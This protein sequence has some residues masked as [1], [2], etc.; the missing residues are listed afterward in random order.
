MVGPKK[1]IRTGRTLTEKQKIKRNSKTAEIEF[2]S[3]ELKVVIVACSNFTT[4]SKKLIQARVLKRLKTAF[5]A[6]E[7]YP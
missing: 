4:R 2:T 5:L 6:M 7:L 1:S 3:S